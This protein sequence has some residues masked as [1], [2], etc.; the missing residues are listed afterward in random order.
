MKEPISPYVEDRYAKKNEF[1]S[2]Q[3]DM[4]GAAGF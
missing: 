1:I 3:P 2:M 4:S